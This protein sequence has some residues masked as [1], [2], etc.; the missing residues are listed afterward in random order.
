MSYA[1]SRSRSLPL[2]LHWQLTDGIGRVAGAPRVLEQASRS[3][4]RQVM[5]AIGRVV[6]KSSLLAETFR[7]ELGVATLAARAQPRSGGKLAE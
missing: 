5:L 6:S 3:R 1:C 2:W 7:D 4:I